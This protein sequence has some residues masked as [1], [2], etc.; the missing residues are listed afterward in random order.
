LNDERSAV[1]AAVQDASRRLRRCRWHPGQ[2]LRSFDRLV[3]PTDEH[4]LHD[5]DWATHR[6]AWEM[7]L[8][9]V[10]GV[11]KAPAA[12]AAPSRASPAS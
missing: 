11:N 12:V 3:D 9:I 10:G 2:R 6:V 1:L 8:A 4:R 5:S 7:K